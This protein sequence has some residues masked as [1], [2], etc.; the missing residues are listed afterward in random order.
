MARDEARIFA[1]IWQDDHFLSLSPTQQRLYLFLLSQPDLSYCGVIAL[2]ER[3]WSKKARGLT[4]EQICEDLEALAL[5]PS[6]NPSANP[7]GNPL[8]GPL[9]VV[10]EDAEEVFVRS[11]IRLDGIWKQP[12]LLKAAREAARLVQSRRIRAA[13]VTELRRIPVQKSESQHVKKVMGEFIEEFDEADGNPFEESPRLPENP[14][15]NPSRNPSPDPSQGKGGSNGGK[16]QDSP[17]PGIP[18]P[19]PPSAAEPAARSDETQGQRVNRLARVYTDRV[20]P[21]NFNAVAGIVRKA[22]NADCSDELITKGLNELADEGRSCTADSLRIAMYGRPRAAPTES[23]NSQILS[24]AMQ[25]AQEA[26]MRM[27]ATH[28]RGEIPA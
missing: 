3:R 14:S 26:E 11:L 23:R 9:L 18:H 16:P 15:P 17:I 27:N 19:V 8:S 22:V 12:N 2:R 24:A 28:P 1:A 25:R 5:D 7:S 10:D 20:K 13:L 21:S 4:V 6:G